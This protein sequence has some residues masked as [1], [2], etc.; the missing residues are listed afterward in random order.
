MKL[1]LI[2]AILILHWIGDFVFQDDTTAKKKADSI[3]WLFIHCG[4]YTI[5]LMSLK[6]ANAMWVIFNGLAH[7]II[8]LITSKI[9]KRLWNKGDRHNFFVCIGFDQMLH[10]MILIYTWKWF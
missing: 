10:Y 2:F 6:D 8:D 7:F 9:N 4:L 1:E 5:L 3:T